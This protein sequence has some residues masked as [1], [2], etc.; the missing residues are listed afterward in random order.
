MNIGP[1][2]YLAIKNI[3]D[4]LNETGKGLNESI[5][6]EE[7]EIEEFEQNLFSTLRMA[8]KEDAD[9]GFIKL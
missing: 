1:Y 5:K 4:E 9:S 6:N 7:K 2:I 8:I 3:K